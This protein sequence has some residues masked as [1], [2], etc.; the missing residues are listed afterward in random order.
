[1]NWRGRVSDL[2][3]AQFDGFETEWPEIIL[4]ILAARGVTNSEAVKNTLEPSLKDLRHPSDLADME[5]ACERLAL[6]LA[7]QETIAVYGD[8]DLDGTSGLALLVSG[9][10]DFGFQNI[11]PYQPKRLSEGYGFHAHAVD[12]LKQQGVSLIVTVDVGIT[13]VKACQRANEM[14]VDVIITDHHLPKQHLP[15]AYAIVNPN[16]GQCTSKLQHLCG[17]GVGY[18]LLLGL[19]VH[20]QSL[21]EKVAF[22]PKSVLDFF[23]I[24]TV[25]DMVPLVDENRVLVQHGLHRLRTKPRPGFA[26][27]M[28]KLGVVS[29]NL[30]AKELA[31]R[32]APKLNALSRLEEGLTPYMVYSVETVEEAEA[33]IDKVVQQNDRRVHLQRLAEEMAEFDA[34]ETVSSGYVFSASEDYHQGVVGL[35]A[36]K[37]TQKFGVPSFIGAIKDGGQIVGSARRPDGLEV[38]LL[39]GL[40]SAKDHQVKLGGHAAASG[41]EMDVEQVEG[42]KQALAGFYGKPVDG[43]PVGSIDYDVAIDLSVA[44]SYLMKWIERLQPFGTGFESPVFR[45]DGL[46]VTSVKLLKEIH[47]KVQVAQGG[48]RLDALWFSLGGEQLELAQGLRI[49]DHVDALGELGWN[50]FAGRRSLQLTLLDL[51]RSTREPS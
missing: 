2:N 44:D 28:K 38:S 8:F 21:G 18:Y 48:A 17:A 27:L 3:E 43:R 6:A 15:E 23:A 4:S 19:R 25:T 14:G 29:K 13:D 41:F 9:L 24:G 51:R 36:T 49:G 10:R 45:F 32:V 50:E 20:L 33:L 22:D 40:V 35:V 46:K 16:S 42:F 1:M 47:L 12:A 34:E 30:T 11:I 26:T 37:M 31:I 7:N 39:D 5:R